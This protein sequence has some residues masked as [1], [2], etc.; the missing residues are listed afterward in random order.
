MAAERRTAEAGS[1]FLDGTVPYILV[2]PQPVGAHCGRAS[3]PC[4][5]PASFR[6][7]ESHKHRM[8]VCIYTAIYGDYDELKAQPRQSVE[9]DFVCF[10]E[11][12]MGRERKGWRIIRDQRMRGQH[13]RLRAKYFKVRNDKVFGGL[14]SRLHGLG[15]YDATI[16]IDGSIQI[17]STEFV[18]EMIRTVRLFGF[19][20]ATHPKR[21]CIYDELIA[22]LPYRKYQGLPLAEQVESYRRLGYPAH[23]GLMARGVIVR[24]MKNPLL[25]KINSDWWR[26]N[27]KWSYQDQLS[28]PVVLWKRFTWYDPFQFAHLK[29]DFY[30]HSTHASDL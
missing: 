25:A 28:L 7:K 26:E 14:Y 30:E 2:G 21:D 27:V 11:R 23:N 4:D 13:P 20:M 22:S 9:T 10:T 24:M 29:N 19:G 16:W 12:T 5:P 1:V 15:D 8:R 18:A 6:L 17:V 3:A